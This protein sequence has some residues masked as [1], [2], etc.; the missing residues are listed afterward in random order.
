MIELIIIGLAVYGAKIAIQKGTAAAEQALGRFYE[1]SKQRLSKNPVLSRLGSAGPKVAAGAATAAYGSVLAPR[2]FF[3]DWRENWAAGREEAKVR[4][5]IKVPEPGEKR[6]ETPLDSFEKAFLSFNS[7]LDESLARFRGESPGE[8]TVAGETPSERESL[9]AEARAWLLA[10]PTISESDKANM[11]EVGSRS[12][13]VREAW[14]DL[15]SAYKDHPERWSQYQNVPPYDKDFFMAKTVSQGQGQPHTYV[16]KDDPQAPKESNMTGQNA[17]QVS[18]VLN[19]E[20]LKAAVDKL[21]KYAATEADSASANQQGYSALVNQLEGASASLQQVNAPAIAQHVQ[22]AREALQAAQAAHKQ[23]SA[24]LDAFKGA[25]DTLQ[26]DVAAHQAVQ[27][28][29]QAV[30]DKG[31]NGGFY[32]PGNG[33][34]VGAGQFASTG[35]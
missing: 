19:L 22:Q 17:P 11:V 21:N 27:D 31:V 5:G 7:R 18:E 4:W 13:S 32:S 25:T 26:K 20:S 34:R 35:K 16:T 6:D 12:R 3:R 9:E 10:D 23:V 33:S 29:H 14:V 15:Y 1:D 30:Q 28:A 8:K 2:A 24:S